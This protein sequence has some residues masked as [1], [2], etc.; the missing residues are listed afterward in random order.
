MSSSAPFSFPCWDADVTMGA[1]SSILGYLFRMS[2]QQ[3]TRG[4]ELQKHDAALS[5]LGY[6]CLELCVREKQ[7]FVLFKTL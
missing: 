3:D 2:E 4:L 7:T 1:G 5:A 6:L